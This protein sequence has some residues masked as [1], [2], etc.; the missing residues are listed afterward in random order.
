M[1]ALFLFYK[2]GERIYMIKRCR[3]THWLAA[4]ALGLV[5]CATDSMVDSGKPTTEDRDQALDVL[6]QK[7]GA[8]VKVEINEAGTTRVI[9]MTPRFPVAGHATDPAEVAKAF[10]ADNHDVF[11]LS[12]DDAASFVVTRV[13]VE[14]RSGLRHITLQRTF[15]G[16]PAF[17]G[18]ITV[19][20][21]SGNNVF[22]VL[23]DEFYRV[24][25]PTNSQ[26]LTPT[27]AV[28]AAGKGLGINLSPSFVS[29]EGLRTTF[30]SPDTLDLINVEPRILQLAPT[31]NR[32]VYQATVS[33]LDSHKEQQY[34]LVLIDAQD[35]KILANHSLVNT[36]QGRVFTASPGSHPT[37]DTRE[38][39]SFNGDP[40][41]SPSGWVGTG[42]TTVGNNAVACTDLNANNSC[43]GTNE[44]QPVAD[45][46]DSFDFP[47][48]PAMDSA[49][50]K[51]A[52]V[53]SAFYLVNDYHDR[54]YNLGFTEAAG[55]FQ[56][57]NLGRGGLANDEVQV[58]AQDGSGTNNANFATPPDGSKP[59]MQ[60]FLFNIVSGTTLRQD[61]DFDPTVIYHENTHG[62]SNRLV[63]GGSTVC[64]NGLQSGG[65][66]EGW[67]DF[68]GSSFLNNPVVGA[69]VTGDATVGIRQQSMGNSTWTYNDIKN[70]NLAEV[71]DAGELWA[72]T[73]WTI[74]NGVGGVFPTLGTGALG[75][76]TTE[77]LVIQG[78]KLTPCN[79]TMLQ[80][81][82][83][84]LAADEMLNAGAN[85]CKLLKAFASRLMGT[86]ASSPNDNSTSAIV[87]STAV[88]IE[89]SIDGVTRT[90][91]STD[92]NKNIPDN[93]PVG[94]T[95]VIN[96][97]DDPAGID[98]RFVT[99]NVN[100]NHTFRGD[101]VVQVIAPNGQTATLTNHQ[102]GSADDFIVNNLDISS[103]F[104]SMAPAAGQW[105]LFV[106][107]I[108]ALDVGKINSFAIHLTST[109]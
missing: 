66:G 105:K 97:P 12:A 64:L 35:G 100:I 57:N 71:H 31:D 81:R 60:M 95:S 88:P 15:N 54:T 13:D 55:N 53:T 74:R 59:R 48:S 43:A 93:N 39:K 7:A 65:M 2:R 16:I 19:H 5:A 58:D 79:P 94:V 26:V 80:A 78:M 34:Q 99:V 36:F 49:G 44:T 109:H 61:G 45:M 40:V 89:C 98:I 47:F 3:L 50:F 41:A 63:G 28:A 103:A 33:W 101:L 32:F 1:I 96:V 38:V 68:M 37:M 84:I 104:T 82:D 85:R 87:T 18:G 67:G 30:T 75:S 24:S 4:S 62:V 52:S 46:T 42:R 77:A 17:Q 107:D 56:T 6:Q 23:G 92:V 21:D 69:Y 91:T 76:A 106:K 72:A 73:L 70:G 108:A 10:L 22:R 83:G 14:P 102:G 25:A 29:S 86:G 20:M 9:A 90:F 11:Q 51:P 8:P 27:E